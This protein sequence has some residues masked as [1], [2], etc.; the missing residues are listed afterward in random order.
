MENPIVG[1]RM[2]KDKKLCWIEFRLFPREMLSFVFVVPEHE[3]KHVFIIHDHEREWKPF[4]IKATEWRA[5]YF[6]QL[7]LKFK[8]NHSQPKS[9]SYKTLIRKDKTA[10]KQIKYFNRIIPN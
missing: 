6:R 10:L 7:I 5:E 3:W 1:G 2:K 4:T 9:I 8:P